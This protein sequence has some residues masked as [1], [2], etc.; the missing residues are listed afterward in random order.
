MGK[1]LKKNKRYFLAVAVVFVS[2]ALVAGIFYH[3]GMYADSKV[4]VL[5]VGV[6]KLEPMGQRDGET[7]SVGQADFLA[8]ASLDTGTGEAVVVSIP[9]DTLVMLEKYSAKGTYLGQEEGQLCL[10]YAMGDG[11]GFSCRLVEAQVEGLLGVRLDGYVAANIQALYTLNQYLGGVVV[12]M[13]EDYTYALSEFEKGADVEMND[14]RLKAFL[15]YRDKGRLDGSVDRMGRIGTF[16]EALY[17]RLREVL[18]SSPFKA[19]GLWRALEGDICTDLGV[20]DALS[21]MPFLGKC[22]LDDGSFV[23]LDGSY[24]DLDGH[25]AFTPSVESLEAVGLLLGG[26]NE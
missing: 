4:N 24:W 6:D 23:A 19:L 12:H 3:V 9:R 21:V 26:E 16:M 14:Y 17:W 5:L 8:V 10:Q 13:D 22:A 2:L 15:R 20:L 1:V 18:G 11:E 7:N 25:I